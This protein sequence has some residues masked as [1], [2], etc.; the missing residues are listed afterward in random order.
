MSAGSILLR[1]III[2]LLLIASFSGVS[3]A[4]EIWEGSEGILITGEEWDEV[5]FDDYIRTFDVGSLLDRMGG[6]SLSQNLS[7]QIFTS[8]DGGILSP[9]AILP[10]PE[11]IYITEGSLRLTVN[12]EEVLAERGQAV[13]IPPQ[14]IRRFEN[15]A[16]ETLRF[17]SVIDWSSVQNDARSSEQN[18]TTEQED[19]S[20]E[21]HVISEDQVT[22]IE[23]GNAS[24][25]QSFTFSRLLHPL[26]GLYH[27][28]FDIG[29]ARI[30]EG[31]SI[32]DHYVESRYQLITVLS[33]FGTM[34]VGCHE[35]PV[36]SNSI[37]YVAPGAV[38]NMTA[39]DDMHLMVL[40]NPYY[41]EKYDQQMPYA[42]DYLY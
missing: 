32:A 8:E 41:Q 2:Q 36:S 35:Y 37:I 5:Q 26:E 19:L 20:N 10:V 27:L 31:S 38:M 25:Q 33:G 22:L 23:L 15:A 6:L 30:S 39:S 42:C 9:D 24:A 12:E 17:F 14:T 29:T 28:G 34:W 16:N 4:D 7:V 11:V 40:T 1:V 3:G 21:T 13:Y 18:S